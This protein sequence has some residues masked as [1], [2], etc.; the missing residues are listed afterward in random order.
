MLITYP[1]GRTTLWKDPF[2]D[3]YAHSDAVQLDIIS[4]ETKGRLALYIDMEASA[5]YTVLPIVR[6][7][8][9]DRYF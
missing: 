1:A 3:C 8:D 2:K 4:G 7:L 9:T 5:C 6:G